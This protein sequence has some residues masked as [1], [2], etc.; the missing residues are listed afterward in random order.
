MTEPGC[1]RPFS[2]AFIHINTGIRELSKHAQLEVV[3]DPSSQK[4]RTETGFRAREQGDAGKSQPAQGQQGYS[5]TNPWMGILRDLRVFWHNHRPFFRYWKAIKAARPD[6]IYERTA[7]LNYCGLLIAKLLGI[8]HFYEV[9]GV[10]SMDIRRQYQS[11]LHP[12]LI[13][14]ERLSYRLATR[15]F[16]VGGTGIQA[17]LKEAEFVRVQNG[18]DQSFLDQCLEGWQP[19]PHDQAVFQACFIGHLMRHHHL[20]ILFEAWQKMKH[21]ERWHFHFMGGGIFEE[22]LKEVPEGFPF[23]YHGIVPHHELPQHL[24]NLDVG[25]IPHSLPEGSNMKVYTYGA[26][27]LLALVPRWDNFSRAFSEE[28]VL[29]FTPENADSLAEALDRVAAHPELID[30]KGT[31]LYQKIQSHYTWEKI[32]QFTYEHIQ[33]HLRE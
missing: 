3:A 32:F 29:F 33:R 20:P 16:C 6:F 11:H 23:T 17:G 4:Y 18:I 24:R 15:A 28:E 2:G 14:M 19:T 22:V 1:L 30:A 31:E 25:L 12:L 26:G 8:P 7:Y 21:P 10:T 13:R 5:R 27:K 9:N